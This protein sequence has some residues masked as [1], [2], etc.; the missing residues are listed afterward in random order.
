MRACVRA[1]A[2][3]PKRR[4]IGDTCGEAH[5]I[6]D[7]P[8]SD[9]R[10]AQRLSGPL[11]GSEQEKQSNHQQMGQTFVIHF[12]LLRLEILFRLVYL[13]A[14]SRTCQKAPKTTEFEKFNEL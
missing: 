14:V 11:A 6:H 12:S 5:A 9:H 4:R 1:R 2:I 10:R 8:G 3:S 13:C 7:V